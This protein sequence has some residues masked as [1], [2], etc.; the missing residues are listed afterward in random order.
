MT[1]ATLALVIPLASSVAFA[2]APEAEEAV[3]G[4][5]PESI[6]FDPGEA[7]ALGS[8]TPRTVAFLKPKRGRLPQNPY[9][10]IDF[11]AYAL[12]WG[13]VRMGLGSVT[14]GV[15]PRVQLGTVP[16]LD[17]MGVYNAS[18]KANLLRL[19]PVDLAVG[20]SH[21]RLPLE[22]FHGSWTAA[23]STLSVRVANPWS[24]HVTGSYV[25][26]QAKGSPY[27]SDQISSWILTQ[28]AGDDLAQ[29]PES[30]QQEAE[31]RAND[32]TH[33]IDAHGRAVT[34]RVATDIRFNRRDSLVLQGQAMLWGEL[35]SNV[36]S[37]LPPIMGLNDALDTQTEETLPIAETYVASVAWQMQWKRLELR[38]GGGISSV[39]GA[40]LLQSTDLAWRF[41]GKTRAGE[42]RM[43]QAWRRDKR[44]TRQGAGDALAS[45]DRAP[46]AGSMAPE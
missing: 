38:V 34:L 36:G 7:E 32:A 29:Q 46:D 10:S 40:W 37:D 45:A 25:D 43:R 11:T 16:V 17:A 30:V 15:L 6:D 23:S 42:R 2:D 4:E 39:P 24:L 5:P 19:G 26:L 3:S 44:S 18:A 22:T 41:G 9:G 13:E 33:S 31:A 21:Y 12:E 27:V 1:L 35:D 14:V 8:L 28:A 20:G